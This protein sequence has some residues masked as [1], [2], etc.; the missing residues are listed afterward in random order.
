MFF[1][2]LTFAG[3]RGCCLKTRPI[4]R[5]FKHLLR[6][7]A[8]INT[9]IIPFSDCGELAASPVS[10]VISFMVEGKVGSVKG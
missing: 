8:S 5:V 9:G 4:D 7:P 3:S 2:A 6:D 10:E 1:H